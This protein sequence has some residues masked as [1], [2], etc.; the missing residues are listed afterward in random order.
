MGD[1]ELS[2]LSGSDLD[3][4]SIMSYDESSDDSFNIKKP[5]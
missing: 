5:A 3:K 2:T 4:N 1:D